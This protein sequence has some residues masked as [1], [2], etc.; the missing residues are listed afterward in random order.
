MQSNEHKHKWKLW[1]KKFLANL[2]ATVPVQSTTT[3]ASKYCGTYDVTDKKCNAYT[4]PALDGFDAVAYFDL[5]YDA[6]ETAVL[7]SERYQSVYNSYSFWFSSQK[8]LDLFEANPAQYAP[9][10]GRECCSRA[11][12]TRA[13][14][15]CVFCTRTCATLN[16]SHSATDCCTC[17]FCWWWSR[18][19]LRL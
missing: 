8:N 12:C 4:D 7:G 5:D 9:K 17:V 2:P 19:F 14:Y 18:R 1:S 16:C 6:N 10:Y 3:T 15:A 13:W 11:E